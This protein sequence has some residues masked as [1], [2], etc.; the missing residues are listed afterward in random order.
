MKIE[1][2]KSSKRETTSYKHG[3]PHKAIIWFFSRNFTGQKGLA[4]YIQS[5]EREKF[6]T[7]NTLPIMVIIQN[8]RGREF[9]RQA[10]AK[11]V[12]QH[13]TNLTRNLQEISL[14]GKEGWLGG[15]VGWASYS[16]FHLRSGSQGCGI[17]P[18]SGRLCTECG[19]C[20]RFS[21]SL[22][23]SPLLAHSL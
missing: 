15:S 12:Y 8:R 5:V 18:C 11:G 10:K 2:L 13:Q 16:W 9:C 4:G 17:Q 20:L 1:T 21:L 7:R 19:A 6:I 3:N 14:N 23:L 22:C